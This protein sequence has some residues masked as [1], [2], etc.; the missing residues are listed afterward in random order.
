MSNKNSK[1][2]CPECGYNNKPYYTICESCGAVVDVADS[3]LARRVQAATKPIQDDRTVWHISLLIDDRELKVKLKPDQ[4]A[5]VGREV[6]FMLQRPDIDLTT[7]NAIQMGVSRVHAVLDWQENG[8]AITDLCSRNGT[9]INGQRLEELNR[10]RLQNGDKL[11]FGHMD[12]DF[13]VSED[14]DVSP[15]LSA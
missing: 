1:T 6:P 5:T 8:V 4:R 11:R 10:Y 7:Y 13:S 15:A 12:I 3:T 9:F 2:I 14:E